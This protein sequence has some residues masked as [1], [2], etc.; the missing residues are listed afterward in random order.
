MII[1]YVDGRLG[2]FHFLAIMSNAAMNIHLQ[3]FVCAHVFSSLGHI[4]RCGI[5]GSY[6]NSV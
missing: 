6:D 4:L 5:A 2:C 1:S 3:V